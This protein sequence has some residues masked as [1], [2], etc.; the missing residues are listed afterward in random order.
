MMEFVSMSQ[1]NVRF[2]PTILL[3]IFLEITMLQGEASQQLGVLV[4]VLLVKD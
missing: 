1:A 4:R 3:Q 2:H